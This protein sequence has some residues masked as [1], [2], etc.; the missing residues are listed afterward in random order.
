MA[1]KYWKSQGI[2]SVQKSGNPDLCKRESKP[3]LGLS[4]LPRPRQ[5]GV[6]IFPDREGTIHH[7]QLKIDLYFYKT[8]FTTQQGENFQSL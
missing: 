2:L 8:Q 7:K 5:F 6:F 3:S 1:K 4:G